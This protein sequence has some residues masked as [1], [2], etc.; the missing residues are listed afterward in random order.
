MG[1][2]SPV[3]RPLRTTILSDNL[4]TTVVAAVVVGGLMTG[5]P[6]NGE[7]VER[8][9]VVSGEE[10]YRSCRKR[11]STFTSLFY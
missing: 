7:V 9:Q 3:P 8:D 10:I 11:S 6:S 1:L 2:S 5:S 4:E